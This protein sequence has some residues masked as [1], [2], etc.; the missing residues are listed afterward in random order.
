MKNSLTST[1]TVLKK[2]Q[3]PNFENSAWAY[4]NS[5]LAV[6]SI[7]YFIFR[8]YWLLVIFQTLL[9]LS[10]QRGKLNLR[11]VAYLK[12]NA[13]RILVHINCRKLQEA[14][15]ADDNR[16]MHRQIIRMLKYAN[17]HFDSLFW[18]RQ[19]PYKE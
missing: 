7:N 10:W 19:L 16:M 5:K 2:V 3:Q 15:L 12:A 14:I 1:S 13:K 17:L 9:E 8:L 18:T 4:S 11:K 6:M